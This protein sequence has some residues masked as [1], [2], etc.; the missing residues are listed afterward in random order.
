MRV[1]ATV[2]QLAQRGDLL[3]SAGELSTCWEAVKRFLRVD[4]FESFK[5]R[6]YAGHVC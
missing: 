4:L 5:G 3:A 1:T 2:A 6:G